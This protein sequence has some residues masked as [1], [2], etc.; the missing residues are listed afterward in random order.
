MPFRLD[1][2][3]P[4]SYHEPDAAFGF[5]PALY[6]G[7]VLEVSYSQSP[8][9]LGKLANKYL[10]DTPGPR[11]Q[12]VITL[13]LSYPTCDEATLSVW[14][15]YVEPADT[16]A[17][18]PELVVRCI[19]YLFRSNGVRAPTEANTVSIKLREFA[20]LG[21]APNA[22]HLQD[23]IQLYFDDINAWIDAAV[24]ERF[25]TGKVAD[26]ATT[27]WGSFRKRRRNPT[28]PEE[29]EEEDEEKFRKQEA[30]AG[31][32]TEEGAKDYRP[33]RRARIDK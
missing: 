31:Q 24:N 9:Q 15:R 8:K 26:T 11:I 13:D 3:G 10:L 5:V 19:K 2:K 33:V 27:G 30:Q 23:E 12:V 21:T 14:R 29:L 25:T 22:E 4:I 17:E 18:M 28:P 6:P 20:T 32:K 7:V 1:P 16:E